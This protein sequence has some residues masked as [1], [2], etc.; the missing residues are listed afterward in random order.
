LRTP[1]CVRIL[2][3]VGVGGEAVNG[4]IKGGGGVDR[5]WSPLYTPN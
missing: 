1:V 2:V 4:A 3:S 5:D